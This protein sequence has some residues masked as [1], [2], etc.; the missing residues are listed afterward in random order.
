MNKYISVIADQNL[1][2]KTA[3]RHTIQLH[4]IF[5]NGYNVFTYGRNA[6]DRTDQACTE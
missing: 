6:T 2:L 4:C 5:Q 3:G 1:T